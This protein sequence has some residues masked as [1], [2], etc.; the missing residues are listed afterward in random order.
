MAT[1]RRLTEAL[2]YF[3]HPGRPFFSGRRGRGRPFSF[4]VGFSLHRGNPFS[5]G[6]DA[7]SVRFE[8]FSFRLE[9]P[10]LFPESSLL[11]LNPFSFALKFSLKVGPSNVLFLGFLL[12]WHGGNFGFGRFTPP[13]AGRLRRGNQWRSGHS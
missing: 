1:Q 8:F 6:L 7:A 3:G 13:A 4:P 9:A 11:F 10:S 2:G 5:L 12:P